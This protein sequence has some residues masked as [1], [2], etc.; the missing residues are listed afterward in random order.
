MGSIT[1]MPSIRSN[2]ITLEYDTFGDSSHPAMVLIMGLATQMIAWQPQF[3]RAL[4]KRGFHVIRFDNRDVG[5]STKLADPP[6]SLIA[7]ALKQRLGL[8]IEAPYL[9]SDMADDTVGLLDGLG[10][11]AAHLVGASMGGMIAQEVALGHRDRVLSLT[12]IMSTTGNPK[13]GRP[14]PW[15]ARLLIRRDAASRD[16]AIEMSVDIRR[17]LSPVHFNEK[18]SRNFAAASSDRSFHP[19]GRRRQ[20]AAVMASGDRTARLR[21]LD[22]PTLVIHGRQDSLVHPDGGQATADAI[23]ASRLVIFDQMGHDLPHPLWPE[24]VDAIA[25]HAAAAPRPG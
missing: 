6:P 25:T 23:P 12:S 4:A 17:R 16:E 5:L 21:T 24:L 19:S 20:L 15:L 3:C 8:P 9:L 7:S 22:V 11:E 1:T 14:D 2:G 18:D 13:V 10:I